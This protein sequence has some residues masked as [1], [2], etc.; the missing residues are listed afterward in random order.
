MNEFYE[1]DIE[2]YK[3]ILSKEGRIT[4]IVSSYEKDGFY[5]S[6]DESIIMDLKK[7][8][9]VLINFTIHKKQSL[10]II[11]DMM[12]C[13]HNYTN[14]KAEIIFSTDQVIDID[15]DRVKYQIIITGL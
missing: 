4:G 12:C 2:D 10:F 3:A 8:K 6:L 9:G 11:N 5:E 13:I 14:E 7:A 1:E 15:E